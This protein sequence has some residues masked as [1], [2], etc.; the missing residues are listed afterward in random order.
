MAAL[1]PNNLA[2]IGEMR[3]EKC[4]YSLD[5]ESWTIEENGGEIPTTQ[6]GCSWKL[7]ESVPPPVARKWTGV[8]EY[9]DCAECPIYR[10][11]AE[12]GPRFP[13]F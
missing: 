12:V 1:D 10:D 2:E 9:E 6:P 4:R 7:P 8:V 5:L 13:N 11:A 3:H